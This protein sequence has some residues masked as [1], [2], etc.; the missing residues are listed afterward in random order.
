VGAK[1]NSAKFPKFSKTF[2]KIRNV[3]AEIERNSDWRQEVLGEFWK[4][5]E[6]DMWSAF[7]VG[8]L[9]TRFTPDIMEEKTLN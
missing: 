5:V 8:K 6:I 2:E 3:R 4:N 7:R 9:P 1:S